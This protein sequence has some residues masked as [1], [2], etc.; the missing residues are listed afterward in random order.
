M[1]GIHA[2]LLVLALCSRGITI[3]LPFR[4]DT[5]FCIRCGHAKEKYKESDE[6]GSGD[7][8]MHLPGRKGASILVGGKIRAV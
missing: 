7:S 1:Q 3:Q 6:R 5:N 2:S 8:P 4:Q